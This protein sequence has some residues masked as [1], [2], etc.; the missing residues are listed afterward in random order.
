MAWI[1][2]EPKSAQKV[3]PKSSTKL[4][5]TNRREFLMNK[6]AI[7]KQLFDEFNTRIFGGKMDKLDLVWSKALT[8]CAGKYCVT[9]E[10]QIS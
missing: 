9:I 6:E 8:N 7:A 10:V 2:K 3:V 1:V 4:W 5:E